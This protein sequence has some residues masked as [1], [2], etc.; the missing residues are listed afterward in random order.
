M[1]TLQGAFSSNPRVA[2]LIDGTVRVPGVEIRWEIFENP[3]V[4]FAKQMRDDAF[5]VFEFSISDYINIRSRPASRWDWTALPVFLSKA[6]LQLNTWVNVRSGVAGAEDLKDKRLAV[7][8][9][10][11][12]AFLW[13]RAMIERLYGIRSRDIFWYN[14]RGGQ[15][16]HSVLLG[17]DTSP[18]EGV[19]ITF[20]PGPEAINPLLQS[21]EI[22]AANA[23]SMPIDTKS[24]LV[25]RLFP[26]LG[27]G[28]ME[29]FHSA[30]GFT[31]VNHTV[32]LK[33]R[34][35]EANPWLPEALFEAFERSKEEAYRRDPGARNI[36]RK[37]EGL[38]WDGSGFGDDPYASGL[39]ANRTML[40]MGVDQALKDGLIRE[41]VQADGL[42]W[43]SLRNT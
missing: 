10:T 18:P 30:V 39:A 17:L 41:R 38:T 28:F 35:V 16:S 25:R 32:G 31:P 4:L 3:G 6:L 13:F 12:T 27:K 29:A 15:E 20:L 11:Q 23:T 14:G 8:D 37:Q 40:A 24:P 9:Y 43:E 36:V 5:D 19:S 42:F 1:L 34:V 2:P 26:D 22:D 7:G 21:G 33:R